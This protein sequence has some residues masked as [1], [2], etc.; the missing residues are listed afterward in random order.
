MV[1]K[2]KIIEKTQFIDSKK[3]DRFWGDRLFSAVRLYKYT[4]YDKN[5]LRSSLAKKFSKQLLFIAK[6]LIKANVHDFYF[7]TFY[8]FFFI[9]PY[10]T[11]EK[12]LVLKE[13]DFYNQLEN[14]SNYVFVRFNKKEFFRKTKMGCRPVSITGDY[15]YYFKN[16]KQFYDNTVNELCS[17]ENF[18]KKY[19]EKTALIKYYYNLE[20]SVVFNLTVFNLFFTQFIVFLLNLRRLFVYLLLICLYI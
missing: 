7:K 16:G 20:L 10:Y 2:S 11:Y 18:D 4:D 15:Y 17:D 9:F 12:G 5:R 1:K 14:F 8:S 19:F 3:I 6:Y 13:V